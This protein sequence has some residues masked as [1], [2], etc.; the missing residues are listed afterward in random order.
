[1]KA[2]R[3]AASIALLPLIG[4]APVDTRTATAAVECRADLED[5]I[6]YFAPLPITRTN[7]GDINEGVGRTQDYSPAGV[8]VLGQQTKALFVNEAIRN[9]IHRYV[10][11]AELTGSFEDARAAMLRL[12]GKKD[13]DSATPTPGDRDCD[14]QIG[15]DQATGVS[16]GMIVL[17]YEGIVVASCFYRRAED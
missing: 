10:Y 8:T 2:Y 17:E 5:A 1:M 9:G 13:C 4:A 14:I 12:H 11:S 3:I 6:A 7:G 16:R 15:V